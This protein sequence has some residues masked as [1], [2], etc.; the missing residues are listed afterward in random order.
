M[1]YK[2]PAQKLATHLS[3]KTRNLRGMA[4]PSFIQKTNLRH[5]LRIK[6]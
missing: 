1:Q 2:P 4:V 5:P 3:K 6:K